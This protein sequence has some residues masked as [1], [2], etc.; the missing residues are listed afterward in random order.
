MASFTEENYLKAI[1]HLSEQKTDESVS[2]NELAEVTQTRAASVTDMLKKLADKNYINYKKY[3][4]VKLTEKGNVLAL[5]IIRKHRLWEVFLVEKLGF[6]WDEIHDL[7]EEL[8]HIKSTELTSKLDKFLGY[9]K[10][11]PHGDPI[12]D[13]AGN[14]PEN[15]TFK[16][17]ETEKNKPLLILGVSEDSS[18]F[19]RHLDK[20]G[21]KLGLK[22]MV[23]EISEFDQSVEIVIE[24]E[25]K[26]RLSAEVS[27]NIHVIY[28]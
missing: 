10:F 21:L 19:L 22:I 18:Q 15:K 11:D 12:P 8:E 25:R 2:T 24:G 27:K 9:P 26:I 3:Q 20:L 4:G 17:S 23:N 16:L 13:E 5:K 6:K 1:Y 7:A 28:K 14:L